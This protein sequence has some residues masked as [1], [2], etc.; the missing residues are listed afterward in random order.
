MSVNLSKSQ[1]ASCLCRLEAARRATESAGAALMALRGTVFSAKEAAG[2]QLKTA[3][4][5]AAE[6]WVLG[7]LRAQFPKDSFLCEELFE[8]GALEWDAPGA[9]W[10]IDALDGTRSFVE[11]F[12]GFCVQVAYVQD[13][14]VQ[15]AVVHEPVRHQ[16]YWALIRHGTFVEG[17]GGHQRRLLLQRMN[18]WPSCPRFVD[19]TSPTGIV[20]EILVQLSGE[21]LECGSIGLKI[22][23]VA[24]S[25]AHVFAKE[26]TF[27]LWDIAPGDL[28][29]SEAGGRLGLWAGEAI[30][31]DGRQVYF[32]DLLAS[33]TGLFELMVQK[34]A[35]RGLERVEHL[36]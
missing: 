10:T 6:G 11:G 2:G 23:R 1:T 32:K 15:V 3:V 26:F 28:I 18:D 4:D 5:Q 13:G 22:C 9:Y 24:D 21:F 20:G 12:D 17:R 14:K 31:Y 16:T 35:R 34:L 7:Y 8:Q 25:A 27:K 30:P 33:P 36:H 19:S 29:L